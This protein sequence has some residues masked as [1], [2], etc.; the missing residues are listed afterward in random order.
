MELD[1]LLV[2]LLAL[3]WLAFV[4][5]ALGLPVLISRVLAIATLGWLVHGSGPAALGAALLVF[6]AVL[7]QHV[8]PEAALGLLCV[9]GSLVS[10]GRRT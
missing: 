3:T 10:A 2:V 6:G 5:S 9:A 7:R 4:G 8:G 1:R